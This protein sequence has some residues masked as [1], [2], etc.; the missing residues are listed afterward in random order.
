MNDNGI[1]WQQQ[2]TQTLRNLTKLHAIAFKDLPKKFH[3]LTQYPLTMI[4]T[5]SQ[6]SSNF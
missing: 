5:Y 2:G 4:T 6:I 3:I 1:W